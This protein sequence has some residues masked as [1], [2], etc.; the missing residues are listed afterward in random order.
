MALIILI[1]SDCGSVKKELKSASSLSLCD[2]VNEALDLNACN[3]LKR[4]ET[5]CFTSWLR[6][7]HWHKEM[8]EWVLNHWEWLS[9]WNNNSIAEKWNK[10][11]NQT[12]VLGSRE[13]KKTKFDNSLIS[14]VIVLLYVSLDNLPLSLSHSPSVSL[15]A[16]PGSVSTLRCP[17]DPLATQSS[18]WRRANSI[19][20]EFYPLISMETV[21]LQSRLD[22]SRLRSSKVV[23]MLRVCARWLLEFD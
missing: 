22:P 21:S 16:A 18:T 13:T 19:S 3:L 6:R 2:T 1:S 4:N 14:S 10:C 5:K 11:V 20:S 9:K 15:M 17:F 7:P 12:S 8:G 23:V